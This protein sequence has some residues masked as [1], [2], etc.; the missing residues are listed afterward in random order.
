ML[1][2][3][4]RR[5]LIVGMLMTVMVISALDKLIFAFA[6]VQIIDDLHLTPEQF[7]LVGSAFFFLYSISGVLVGFLA[8]RCKTRWI[9]VGMSV[10]WTA[11]QLLVAFTH[12]LA[13][14]MASRLLLGAGTGPAT[15]ISQHACFK[16]FPRR[17]RVLPSSLLF[18]SILLGGLLGSVLLPVAITHLG[19]QGAY[20]ALAVL[21]LAWMVVWLLVGREGEETEVAVVEGTP[22]ASVSYRRL[23]LNPTFL[24][25]TV[26]GFLC[27]VPSAM[28]FSWTVVYLN[29]GLGLSAT[30]A[31]VFMLAG[32]LLSI[33]LSLGL[34]SL[35][36]R[37][38]KTG[39]S[40]SALV[41]PP[42]LCALLGGLAFALMAV[43][44]NQ[45]LILPLLFLGSGLT[46]VMQTFGLS[47]IAHFAPV[48][49]RGAM[50]ALFN[51]G[52]TS[53]GMVIPALVGQLVALLQNNIGA[54]VELALSLTGALTV[55]GALAG[56]RLI[57]PEAQRVAITTQVQAVQQA[58]RSVQWAGQR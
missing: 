14:M 16:W 19:W 10:V 50:L 32:A 58:D 46:C 43:L 29:K 23:L 49:R 42:L 9:L 27:Y 55:I 5:R 21:S 11:A 1:S 57:R 13:A 40:T 8:N 51:A 36:Q 2:T 44:H 56:L 3:Y 37:A 34:S 52:Q 15:A 12:T 54:G 24:C 20:L 18:T 30:Q 26:L 17:E 53:A 6:G 47:I 39:A 48:E 22:N 25:A 4:G 45:R 33:V 38:L 7:G 28:S 41:L 35:S 31:G